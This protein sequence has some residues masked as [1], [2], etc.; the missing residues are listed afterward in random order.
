MKTSPNYLPIVGSLLSILQVHGFVPYYVGQETPLTGTLRQRRQ[1]AKSAIV[2]LGKTI[3]H[4]QDRNNN[5]VVLHIYLGILPAEIVQYH[6]QGHSGL[7]AA[8]AEF[9]RK[10]EKVSFDSEE[11]SEPDRYQEWSDQQL[12]EEPSENFH[13]Y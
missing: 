1:A 3:L 2:Q 10:W 13:K 11:K 7:D 9:H 12:L 6:T 5:P 4:A 8:L